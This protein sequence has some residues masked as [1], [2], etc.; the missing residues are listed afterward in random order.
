MCSAGG[1]IAQT[2]AIFFYYIDH[3]KLLKQPICS[4]GVVIA[5]TEAILL[6]YSMYTLASRLVE[7][8]IPVRSWKALTC[9]LD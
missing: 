5:Q 8:F 3:R 2:D 7:T 1:E 9:H 4:G 6:K